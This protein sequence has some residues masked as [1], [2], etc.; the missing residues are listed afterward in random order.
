VGDGDRQAH[1]FRSCWVFSHYKSHSTPPNALASVRL[2][3]S[4]V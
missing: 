3:A 2:R 4:G 1:A